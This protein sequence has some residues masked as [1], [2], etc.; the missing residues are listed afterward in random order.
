MIPTMAAAKKRPLTSISR[1]TEL[2]LRREVLG[3]DRV[4]AGGREQL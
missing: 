2:V 4:L 3:R 1:V